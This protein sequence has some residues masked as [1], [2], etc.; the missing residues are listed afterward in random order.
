MDAIHVTIQDVTSRLE[1]RLLSP[2]SRYLPKVSTVLISVIS[3]LLVFDQMKSSLYQNMKRSW[4]KDRGGFINKSWIFSLFYSLECVYKIGVIAFLNVW[5]CSL[6][7]P[8]GPEVSQWKVF[9]YRFNLFNRYR[10]IKIV[11]SSRI[12]FSKLY[13]SRH[14]PI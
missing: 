4:Y 13:F 1:A 6:M 9:I 3:T 10:T 8:S 14:L 2:S 11:Y 7:K 12:G 5:K